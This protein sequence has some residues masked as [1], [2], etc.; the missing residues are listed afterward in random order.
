ML[1]HELWKKTGYLNKDIDYLFN[2]EIREYDLK[3]ADM[4]LMKQFKLVS[5]ETI[6]SLEK[7]DNQARHVRTGMMQKD[8]K[9]AKVLVE[10]FK[11]ARRMFFEANDIETSD[12]LSIKKD[13]IF[14]I[15]KDCVHHTFGALDFRIKNRYLGY[16][17]LNRLE[18]YFTDS[19]TPLDVKGLGKEAPEKHKDYLLDFIRDVFSYRIYN[20]YPQLIHLITEFI[21]AY[22]NRELD[23]GYYR[24]MDSQ[25]YFRVR[26]HDEDILIDGVSEDAIDQIDISYNYAH[27]LIPI[28][29]FFI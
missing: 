10:A 15:N 16:M 6:A 12:V 5:A 19:N 13:A 7:M 4:S 26:D 18:L 23:I 9:F 29:N 1:Q 24:Q 28:V 14:I 27:Y 8:K 21:T 3:A 11:E 17:N 22:R 25:S 2:C 20:S